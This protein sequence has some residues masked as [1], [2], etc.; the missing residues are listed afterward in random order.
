[1]FC[2]IP[3]E[4]DINQNLTD[5]NTNAHIDKTLLEIRNYNTLVRT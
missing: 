2:H 1:M 4:V 3:K 5:T